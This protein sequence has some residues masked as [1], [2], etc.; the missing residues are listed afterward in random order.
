M[1][2]QSVFCFVTSRRPTDRIVN[3]LRSESFS[4]NGIPVLVSDPGSTA[5]NVTVPP[6]PMRTTKDEAT[7]R[8]GLI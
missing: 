6:A 8:G 4:K 2:K 3:H 7:M 1:S 5:H